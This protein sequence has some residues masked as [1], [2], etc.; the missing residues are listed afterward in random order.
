MAD[1]DNSPVDIDDILDLAGRLADAARPV[2]L[3]RF[4]SGIQHDTKSDASPVTEADRESE[5]TMR[6]LIE[7]ERPN[8]GIFGEEFGVTNPD[9]DTVWI[10]DPIDGTKAFITGK[11]IYGTLIGIV[12]DGRAIAGIIDSPATDDR[13]VGAHGRASMF[14]DQPIETRKGRA[15]KD[16]WVTA[17]SHTMFTSENVTKFEALTAATQHTTYGSECQ[18]YGFLACGWLDL[19]CEDTLAPYDYAALIPIVEGAGGLITDWQGAPLRFDASPESKAGAVI[20]AADEHLHAAAVKIL[21]G[22]AK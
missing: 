18:G 22:R 2:T 9:A 4:R 17:T 8:D 20:A 10:L 13:W 6:A 15:L 11:P 3:A 19:V 1:A 5:R 16:A 21:S 7:A 14:N 12:R